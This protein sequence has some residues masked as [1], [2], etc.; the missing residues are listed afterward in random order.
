MALWSDIKLVSKDY[1]Q[2]SVVNYLNT[3]FFV[4]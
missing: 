4:A 2:Q 3:L 1:T